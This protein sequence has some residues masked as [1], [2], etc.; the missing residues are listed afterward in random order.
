MTNH[1]FYNDIL[2][3]IPEVNNKVAYMTFYRGLTYGKLKK[4]LVLKTPLSK[5]ELTT[6]RGRSKSPTKAPIWERIQRDKGQSSKRRNYEPLPQKGL[7]QCAR[8]FQNEGLTPLRVS[9]A[10][11][12]AQIEGKNLLPK[13]VR[14]RSAPGRRDKTHYCE[15]H[16]EHGHDTNECKILNAE[17]V[18]LIKRGYSKEFTGKGTQRDNTCQNHRS[19]PPPQVKPEPAEVP[20]L[21]GR[22]D[23]I[24]SGIAGGGDSRNS[25]KNYARREVY[26]ST[27]PPA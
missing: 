25:R 13:P 17:I 10:E 20:R 23:T 2:L 19:P 14:M 16:R 27:K 21:T 1:N 5:D 18:K 9:R 22:I 8:R 11:V 3:I 6:R 4:A 26:Q 7:V 15:Y 12:Y 24:S